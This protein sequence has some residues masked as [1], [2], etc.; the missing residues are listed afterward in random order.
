MVQRRGLIGSVFLYFLLVFPR[1][2]AAREIEFFSVAANAVTMYD[3]PS[4]NAEKLYVASLNLPLEVVAKV[5]GWVKVRDSSGAVAW[6]ERKF[7]S[8]KRF[9]IVTA[10]LADVFEAADVHSP[11]IFRVQRHVVLEWLNSDIAGWVKVRHRD[12]QTGYIRVNQVWG[13]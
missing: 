13:S 9:I 6:I 12:G 4:L 11:L 5:E 7:L 3:A 8:D 2:S 1:W 10:S